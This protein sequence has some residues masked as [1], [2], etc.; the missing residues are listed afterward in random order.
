MG[1]L[2]GWLVCRRVGRRWFGGLTVVCGADVG[3]LGSC[4]LVVRCVCAWA[5]N[6]RWLGIWTCR[7][8]VALRWPW[9]IRR[10][11][12]TLRPWDVLLS[13]DTTKFVAQ[14]CACLRYL[15]MPW[16]G[17]SA[18]AVPAASPSILRALSSMALEFSPEATTAFLICNGGVGLDN[19]N[20]RA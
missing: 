7:T 8:S 19:L 17:H 5:P 12:A 6:T 4:G 16:S 1:C 2:V 15:R 10:Y 20:W 18:P 13:V 3:R 9:V 14:S 11:R